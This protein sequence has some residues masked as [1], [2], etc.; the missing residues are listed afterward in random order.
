[1][2]TSPRSHLT[3]FFRFKSE[4]D[5][6]LS[7]EVFNNWCEK[8]VHDHEKQYGFVRDSAHSGKFFLLTTEPM[9]DLVLSGY[10]KILMKDFAECDI[11]VY[12]TVSE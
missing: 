3:Y 5:L 4:A 10:M 7:I 1:M 9:I 11:S 2:S 12:K 6:N 8:Y